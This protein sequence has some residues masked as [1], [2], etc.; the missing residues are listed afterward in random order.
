MRTSRCGFSIV[1]GLSTRGDVGRRGVA[2]A[3]MAIVLPFLSFILVVAVDYCR[4]FYYTQ[5]LHNCAYVGAL[6]ASGTAQTSSALGSTAAATQA[7]V[8]DGTTLTPPLQA[9]NVTVTSQKQTTTVTVQYDY[10]ML[11]PLLGDGGKVTIA[12]Q[13]TMGLAPTA[14][15]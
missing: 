5:T 10:Q 2:A 6:Y 13:V 12:R 14:G 9:R 7:A 8:A 11:T 1:R 3:E 4:I 15:S